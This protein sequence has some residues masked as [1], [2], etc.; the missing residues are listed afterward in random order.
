[1]A[2]MTAEPYR[3]YKPRP[4]TRAERESTTVLFG[5]LYWRPDPPFRWFRP[6]DVLGMS[7]ADE[8]Y[9]TLTTFMSE[10]RARLNPGGRLLLF[11]GTSGDMT[12]LRHLMDRSAFVPTRSDRETS[13]RTA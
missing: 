2:T 10:V 4:F 13:P 8:N 6:R 3:T 9:R 11:F 7:I 12:Y 5:G 1:M